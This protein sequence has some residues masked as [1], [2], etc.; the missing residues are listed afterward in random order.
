MMPIL[1]AVLAD[2]D[3]VLLMKLHLMKLFYLE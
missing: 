1:V 2:I 3:D